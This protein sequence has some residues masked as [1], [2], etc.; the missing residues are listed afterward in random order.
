MTTLT[1]LEVLDVRFPTSRDLEGSDAMHLD[2]DYSAAYVVRHTD[3]G[4]DG[5]GFVFTIGCGNDV[6]HEHFVD[7]VT[8]RDGR[9]RP[10]ERTGFSADLK[11]EAL[12]RFRYP[13]GPEW[14]EGRDA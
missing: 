12:E 9:Y 2:P 13:A 4:P 14:T 3:F 10:P 5:R 8:I 1:R 6:L 11:A 7:P